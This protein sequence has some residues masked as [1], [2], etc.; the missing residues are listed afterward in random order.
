MNQITPIGKSSNYK[1]RQQEGKK[2]R[3]YKKTGDSRKS[4]YVRGSLDEKI[5]ISPMKQ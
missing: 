2:Q 4:S 3:I 1:K 5:L